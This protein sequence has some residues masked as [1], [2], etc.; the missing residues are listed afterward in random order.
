VT[1]GMLENNLTWVYTKLSV[2]IDNYPTWDDVIEVETWIGPSGKNAF[3]KGWTIKNLV[4]GQILARASSTWMMMNINTRRLSKIPDEVRVEISPFYSEREKKDSCAAKKIEKLIDA[5][6]KNKNME[7][8]RSDVDMS[9]H[10]NNVKY[11]NWMLEA[12]PDTIFDEC[13][14]S[15]ITLEFRGEC[16]PSD[17]IQSMCQPHKMPEFK[18]EK[19]IDQNIFNGYLP[20]FLEDTPSTTAF[21]HL[22]QVERENKNKEIV[23]GRTTWKRKSTRE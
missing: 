5:K 15:S 3:Q 19:Y 14:L 23:R 9:H 2:E 18:F 16:G 6:Y 22:L 7:S 8:N 13:Q 20:Y 12:I 4:T 17:T 21:T 10:I 11:A 1:P